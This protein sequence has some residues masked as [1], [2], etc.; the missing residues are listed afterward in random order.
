MPRYKLTIEYDGTHLAGWQR[1]VGQPS[2]QGILQEAFFKFCGEQV[3]P[4]CSGRTDAGV[5]AR[6]QVA[7][8]DLQHSHA[9]FR[10][11]QAVN[12]HLIE[13][14]VIVVDCE[15]VAADFHARF[16]A[17]R[18]HY[19]Y[20]IMNRRARPV[21][22][23]A[24][25]WHIPTELDVIAMQNA[26]QLLVGTHDFSSFRDTRCQAKSPVKTLEKLNVRRDDESVW[27]TTCS[28]SFLHHQVRIMVGTLVNVGKGRWNSDDVA[29]ALAARRRSAA[30]PTAP[31]SGLCFMSVDYS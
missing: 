19:R 29:Q 31:A 17:T 20:Q 2:A 16:D 28:R 22:E 6:G 7:H 13:T 9:A 15:E 8:V 21:L 23:A 27:I 26:A 5:H 12:F 11:L 14:P 1:Q 24:Y 18:R 30:G 25:S 10:V 3:I 4:Q